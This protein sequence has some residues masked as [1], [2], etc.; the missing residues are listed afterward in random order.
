MFE[1]IVFNTRYALRQFAGNRGFAATVVLVTAL[2]IGLNAAMFS[3]I[4]AVLLKPLDYRDPDRLVMLTGGATPIRFHQT[5]AS[6]HSY[7]G[8]GAY[9]GPENLALSGDGPPEVLRGSRVSGD[10]LDILGVRPLLGRSF[11]PSED[12]PGG[13][14]VAMIGAE[15]WRSRFGGSLSVLGRTIELAGQPY[16][17]IGVLPP[18]F[19]F[20]S[21]DTEVWLTRPED[22]PVIGAPSRP[23]SPFLEVFGRLKPGVDLASANAELRVIDGQYDAAHPGMLDSD[24]SIARLWRRPP[25]HAEML[26]NRLVSGVRQKL[27]LLFGAVGLVLTIACA[28]VAS[29]L[30][31]RA[32]ARRHEFAVRAAIGA[33]RG[34]IIGQL[35]TESALLSL[36]GGAIGLALAA[37]AIRLLHHLDR[38]LTPGLSLLDL[39]RAGQI[40]LDGGVL[41]FALL[42]SLFTGLLFGL[43]P[44]LAASHPDLAGEL[45]GNGQR[46]GSARGRPGWTQLNPRSLLVIVQIALSTILLIGSA[47]LIESLARAYR[48]DPG[49]D[50]GHLL[51]MRLAPSATRYDT[52]QKLAAFYQALVERI[53]ALP[54]VSGSAAAMTLP[55]TPSPLTPIQ[56]AAGIQLKLNER[57]LAAFESVTPGYFRTM[58]IRLLR[59]RE[60]QDSDNAAST[61]VCM[62]DENAA[63]LLWP[64]YP[65]GPDPVGQYMRIGSHLPPTEIVGIV[66]GV[67]QLSLTRRPMPGI[68]LPAAQ[69]PP[70]SAMLAVR[71]D[72][73]PLAM[74]RAVRNQILTLDPDQPVSEVATM[75]E[76]LDGSAGQ[77]R[78]M[79]WLLALF[80]AL[81][82][83][84]AVVGLYGVVGYSVARRTKE[85]GIRRALGADTGD[86]LAMVVGHGLRL[87]LGG[88]VLGLCGAWAATR[89][90]ADQLF[91]VEATDP[92]TYAGIGLLFAIVAVAASYAPAKRAAEIDPGI[93]LRAG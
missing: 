32:M 46:T 49:F 86:I 21:A 90:L 60:L 75:R 7:D 80:A 57:P 85:I 35:L 52:Q 71:T 48:V 72:K 38:G 87:T 69:Q 93:T 18:K 23:I 79:M 64:R 1:R 53:D 13:P 56:P 5:L 44:A 73:D 68:Y 10:F 19:Q 8:L 22:S 58:K 47:L 82:T 76:V 36:C 40:A 20:P 92:A 59:G 34:R 70:D 17:V 81:A 43:A 61:P 74:A 84:I 2:G 27:W 30:L 91:G 89:L 33:G 41:A 42:L 62:I 28:N 65:D 31:A 66:S 55:A 9:A 29:L 45:Q 25:V 24:K 88:L 26:K 63:R 12:K 83:I 11:L 4:R 37:A 78:V 14:A 15:L 39:P 50:A 51:T 67:R 54:G 6:A 3:V 77:L 16:T